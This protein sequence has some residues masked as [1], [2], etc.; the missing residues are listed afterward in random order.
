[1]RKHTKIYMDYF[2]YDLSDFIPCEVCN[3]KAVDIHH[4]EPRGMGGDPTGAKD[5]IENLMAL[6]R[7]CHERLGDKKLYKEYLIQKHKEKL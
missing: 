1:M 5:K 3:D 7:S 4:I 2:G 6:C